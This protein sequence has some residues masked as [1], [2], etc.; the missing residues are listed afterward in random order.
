MGQLFR[1]G[2]DAILRLVLFLVVVA[3]VGGGLVAAAIPRSTY[4]TA[5][6]IA[7][8]QPVP[9]SHKHHVGE[10]GIDCRYCHTTV[11]TQATAG[12]P[13]TYTCMTC[14]SQIWTGAAM[15]APVRQ[16]LATGMPL[17]W[18]RVN[19]LPDYVFFNHAI[20]VN[21]GIG[22][23]SCHGPVQQ[24]QLTYRASAFKM[25]FCLDCHRSPQTHVRPPEEVW[26]MSWTPPA[27]QAKVGEELVRRYH[28]RPPS[29][30]TDCSICHR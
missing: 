7:P 22:C 26:N 20:H 8:A 11:E 28:I 12:L 6:G 27:D 10:L 13:P 21:K 15:L 4:F 25:S 5:V 30:L 24:M 3:I 19:R 9:F 14:H 2:A 16:S 23:S 1:P 18:T 29:V 17:H